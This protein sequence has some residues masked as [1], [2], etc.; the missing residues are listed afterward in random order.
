MG[1]SP[2]GG[3][4]SDM[5]K[6]T[7]NPRTITMV[8]LCPFIHLFT[9]SCIHSFIKKHLLSAPALSTEQCRFSLGPR[10]PRT[11]AFTL[12]RQLS[13]ANDWS[14][15]ANAPKL[16]NNPGYCWV[17]LTSWKILAATHRTCTCQ[18]AVSPHAK[19]KV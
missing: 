19:R 7:E 1:S 11:G 8:L 10:L 2:R 16:W 13:T 17:L 15:G 14:S 6:A 5:T 9:H 12:I 3:K 4:E 18:L